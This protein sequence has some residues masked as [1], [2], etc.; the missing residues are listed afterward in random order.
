MTAMSQF[1]PG[2]LRAARLE[3]L[4]RELQPLLRHRYPPMSEQK[5]L[6]Y[7]AQLAALRL[8]GEDMLGHVVPG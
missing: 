2:E 4:I 8:A 7:A 5:L 3:M 1:M 6:S